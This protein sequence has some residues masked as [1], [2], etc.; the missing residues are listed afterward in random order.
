M[1]FG[2][3]APLLVAAMVALVAGLLQSR[4]RPQVAAQSLAVACVSVAA[5][6]IW[7]LLT[8]VLGALAENSFIDRWSA[9][10][11]EL[12]RADDHVSAWI[13]LGAGLILG[14]VLYRA[15]CA[16]RRE[17][18]TRQRLPDCEHGVLILE[19]EQPAAYAVPGRRGGI[20]VSR[21]MIEA[22]EPSE[23]AVLWAHERSHLN[24]KHHR[25]LV[26]TE[27]AAAIVPPLRG[28][29]D[30]VHFATER[31][32]DEDAAME[33]GGDRQLVARAIARAA[34]ASVDHGRTAMA[35]ADTGVGDRVRAMIDIDRRFLAPAIGA[36]VGL[37]VMT[38][39]LAGSGLQLHHLLAFV[40]HVCGG[41]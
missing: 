30:Q 17:R 22:L 6:T 7:A 41:S 11:P 40:A 20:V 37:V 31:W 24:H 39:T 33:V 2:F 4:L 21:G 27:M 25:Y 5:A 28:L 8:L 14:A 18:R 23:R 34:I 38:S 12:Y 35:M 1:S 9:W 36:L 16:A 13:G 19:S 26:A 3:I 32:A 29:A 15:G 10:C